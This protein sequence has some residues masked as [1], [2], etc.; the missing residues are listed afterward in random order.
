MTFRRIDGKGDPIV[1]VH[2]L[3][4]DHTTWDLQR[5]VLAK[6]HHVVSYDVRGHG[7]TALGAGDGSARQLRDDLIELLDE[8]ALGPALLVGFSL[9]GVVVLSAAAERPDLASGV[10][11]IASSS[12]VGSRAADFYRERV[13]LFRE[14]DPAV[15]ESELRQGIADGLHGKGH[16]AEA[17]GRLQAQLKAVGDGTGY[18]NAALAMAGLHEQPL[19]P[20][21][22]RIERP[23]LLIGAEHDAFCPRKAQDIMLAELRDA[24]YEEIPE[25]GHLVLLE[26]P[27]RVTDAIERFAYRVRGATASDG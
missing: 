27:D 23:V 18:C 21:L 25:A 10:V 19:T 2:G 4:E 11:A 14:G 7:Q 1:L 20:D 16:D 3:G 15:I 22:S 17:E 13:R 12:V 8:L 9:G 24:H 5:H 26:E 6:R